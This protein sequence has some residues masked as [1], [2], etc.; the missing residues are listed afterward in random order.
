M[1]M[2]HWPFD[3]DPDCAVITVRQITEEGAPIQHVTHDSE[4]HGWQF[5]TLVDAKEQDVMIVSFRE[6][7]GLDPTL[8]TLAELPSGWQ[9]WR[10]SIGSEWIREPNPNDK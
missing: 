10:Q 8:L 5:L 3:Q 6:V 2:E 7:V 1:C 9:A 4:D